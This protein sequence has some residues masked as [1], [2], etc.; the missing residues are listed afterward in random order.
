MN[1]EMAKS[2]RKSRTIKNMWKVSVHEIKILIGAL[3]L[4]FDNTK[5]TH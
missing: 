3:S 4:T 2:Q 1:D 5:I